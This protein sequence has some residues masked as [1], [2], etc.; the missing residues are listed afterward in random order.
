MK[1]VAVIIIT[2]LLLANGSPAWA[3]IITIAFNAQVDAVIDD[4]GRFG[5]NINIGSELTGYYNGV[6]GRLPI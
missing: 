1:K 2:V 6:R 4:D 3:E 5:G